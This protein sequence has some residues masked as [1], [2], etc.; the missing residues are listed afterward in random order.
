[1]TVPSAEKR[2]SAQGDAAAVAA[3]QCRAQLAKEIQLKHRAPVISLSF[4][5]ADA[6]PLNTT[7]DDQIAPPPHRVLICSE[8]QFKVCAKSKPFF[9]FF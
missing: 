1:M 7:S 8:E 9:F 4:L 6:Q 2:A 5:D 3:A